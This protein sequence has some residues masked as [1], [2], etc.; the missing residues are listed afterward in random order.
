MSEFGE[1][2]VKDFNS[3]IESEKRSKEAA[4]VSTA[5]VSTVL[6]A[7]D[8]EVLHDRVEIEKIEPM[9]EKQYFGPMEEKQYFVGG[10]TALCDAI[11][12]AI[13]HIGNVHKYM[14]DEDRPEKT[15]FVITTDGYENASRR[16]DADRVHEMMNRQ[17]EKYGWKFIFYGAKIN[18]VHE[19]DYHEDFLEGRSGHF[20]NFSYLC[21]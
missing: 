7:N 21:L 14:R 10:S 8:S 20:H 13:H 17:E 2:V 9:T 1:D 11:G 12:D 6:F 3:R 19:T 16:Y 5:L 15:I 18:P 4:H